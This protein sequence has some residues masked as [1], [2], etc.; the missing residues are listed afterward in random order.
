MSVDAVNVQSENSEQDTAIRI[1][2]LVKD[3]DYYTS[4]KAYLD[5]ISWYVGNT[6]S[7]DVTILASKTSQLR[8]ELWFSD[9]EK[10][11]LE[12]QAIAASIYSDE[13][14]FY[15]EF[16][17]EREITHP[18]NV[19]EISDQQKETLKWDIIARMMKILEDEGV[20]L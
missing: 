19:Y 16:F 12:I 5:G 13:S 11:D 14:K 7:N 3:I 8:K 10:T 15:A 18:A 1:Q 6:H 4:G 2:A 17:T 20:T 9:G